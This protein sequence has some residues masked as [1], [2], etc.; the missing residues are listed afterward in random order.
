MRAS[1]TV[2]FAL[3]GSFA[4]LLLAGCSGGG[5]DGA[6]QGERTT[7]AGLLGMDSNSS[8][9]P[10]E[11]ERAAQ[12]I[13]ADCMQQEGWEYIPVEQPDGVFEYSEEDELAR[14]EREGFGIAYYTLY[15]GTEQVDDPYAEWEDPNQDYVDSLSEAERQ[16]YYDSLYGTQEE[17]EAG[18]IMSVDPETGDEYG[19]SYG[20]GPGCQ[21][22]G[23]GGANGE[24]SPELMMA[25]QKY[26]QELQDRYASDPRIIK[27]NDDWSSCMADAGYDYPSQEDFWMTSFQDLQKRRD[28]IVGEDFYPDP[29][30]GWSEDEINAF[31]EESSQEEIDALFAKPPEMT[32]EQRSGLEELLKDEISIATANY[33]CSKP[34]RDKMQD[35]YADIEEQY[36]LEHE[37][38]LKALA[39]SAAS[40]E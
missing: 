19:E 24:Q 11:A 31:F 32:D 22:E 23:Y 26:Y 20:P 29:F 37:D 28:D 8:E 12:K 35:V 7:I 18:M 38:E 15:Q 39:A 33:E 21:G 36:A 6:P 25:M 27:M 4:A 1:T 10:E 9:D 16:A 13:I 40:G 34:Q 5:D 30:A 17:Q 3:A 14:I 2:S